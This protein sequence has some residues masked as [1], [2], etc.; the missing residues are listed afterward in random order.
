MKFQQCTCAPFP[1][2]K[3]S[4]MYVCSLPMHDFS[5]DETTMTSDLFYTSIDHVLEATSGQN[6]FCAGSHLPGKPTWS[7]DQST[8]IL[9]Y[10][11]VSW[12][13]FVQ[14]D[15]AILIVDTFVRLVRRTLSF[16]AST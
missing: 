11:E 14:E 3:V 4:A 5:L 13:Y 10:C 9:K 6:G 7:W 8:T 16:P 1:C 15:V 2:T 12:F